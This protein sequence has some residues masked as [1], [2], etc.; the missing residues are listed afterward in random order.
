MGEI[1]LTSC[2]T[3]LIGGIIGTI[4]GMSL[5]TKALLKADKVYKQTTGLSFIKWMGDYNHNIQM[6]RID[7]VY[8]AE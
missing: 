5:I 4:F 6:H 8:A 3:A 7:K 2:C 1:I